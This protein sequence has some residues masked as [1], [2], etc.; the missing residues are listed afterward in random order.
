MLTPAGRILNHFKL[1]VNSAINIVTGLQDD[2]PIKMELLQGLHNNLCVLR[3][4]VKDNMNLTLLSNVVLPM[5]LESIA[6]DENY[7][8]KDG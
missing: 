8:G 6:E 1:S 2:D 3:D 4:E 7:E 5:E